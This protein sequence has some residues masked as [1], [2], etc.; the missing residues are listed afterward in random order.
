[1]NTHNTTIHMY[2]KNNGGITKYNNIYVWQE[3][4][5]Y[6]KIQQY[7]CMTRTT[8]VLQN[9]TIYM[10]DKNNGGIIKYNNIYV[11]QEQYTCMTRTTDVLQNTTIYMYDKNNIHVWQEQRRYLNAKYK[12]VLMREICLNR[13]GAALH[14]YF[15]VWDT[16]IVDDPTAISKRTVSLLWFVYTCNIG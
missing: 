8:E 2:E 10:Y 4:R 9:T 5:R 1:M 15:I 3:Q 11:W 12:L 16:L 14:L 7:T 6:C 13:T